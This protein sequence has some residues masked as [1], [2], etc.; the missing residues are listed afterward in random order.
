MKTICPHPRLD[1]PEV[2]ETGRERDWEAVDQT[3][4]ETGRFGPFGFRISAR[5]GRRPRFVGHKPR[6]TGAASFFNALTHI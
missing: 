3:R 2:V 4:C 1:L 6:R 5:P